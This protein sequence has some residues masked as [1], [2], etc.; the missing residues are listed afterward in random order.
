M[1]TRIPDI[2]TRAV[3]MIRITWSEE[4][5]R[6]RPSAAP[7]RKRHRQTRQLFGYA[8]VESEEQW[9]SIASTE[10]CQKWWQH[11]GDIMPSNPD[12]SPVSAPLREVFHLA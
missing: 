8:A 7:C 10:A 12:H 11:M 5:Q 9:A 2:G 3:A 4:S 6:P 1:P